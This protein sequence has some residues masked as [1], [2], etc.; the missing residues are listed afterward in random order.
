VVAQHPSAATA[1]ASVADGSSIAVGG[2]GLCGVPTG[3]IR[4]LHEQGAT[5]LRIV[6]NNC[7]LEGW[8]L[9]LLL[10]EHRIARL[11]CSYLGEHRE[12]E[13]Q[14]LA[15]EL[16]VELVPQGTLAE[17][18]RA[19]GVGIPAFFTPAG[20]G[21]LVADGGLPRRYAVDGTVVG[22]SAAK[23]VRMFDGTAYVLETA[24]VTDFAFVRAAV[25]DTLGNLAFHSTARNFNPLCA[26]AGFVT[27]AEVEQIVEAGQLAPDDVHL[28]GVFVQ[29]LVLA[30]PTDEKRIER[31]TVRV[32]AASWD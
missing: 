4:A 27:V 22:S 29:H 1:V 17:R 19:G 5:G 31:R 13:R 6:S 10:Q 14:Y 24:I 3:L 9:G 11:T 18:L 21:T 15:G 7:G 26:M 16:E 32:P 12:L 30:D 20:V 28:P 23:E 2:F 8:G 25:A